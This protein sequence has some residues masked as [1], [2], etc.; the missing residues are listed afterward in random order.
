MI[1]ILTRL[2]GEKPQFA[3]RQ[4]WHLSASR[5]VDIVLPAIAS[6][7]DA[8]SAL[9]VFTCAFLYHSYVAT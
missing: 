2:T 4:D 8:S 6:V 7:R 3:A 9:I 1:A 5:V